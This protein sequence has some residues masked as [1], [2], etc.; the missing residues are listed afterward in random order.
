MPHTYLKC[1]HLKLHC[2]FPLVPA[3]AAYHVH[4]WRALQVCWPSGH[5]IVTMFC[6]MMEYYQTRILR[7]KKMNIYDTKN[8]VLFQFCDE[9]IFLACKIYDE[10][11]NTSCAFNWKYPT[12]VTQ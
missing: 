9:A 2:I 10:W 11:I 8:I 12:D 7:R 3:G 5:W 6:I 1:V 4:R